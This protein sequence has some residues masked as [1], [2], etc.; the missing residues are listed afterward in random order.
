MLRIQ[1]VFIIE[2]FLAHENQITTHI[3]KVT[4]K[5]TN[6]IQILFYKY[7]NPVSVIL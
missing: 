5:S 4:Y 3:A 6:K 7:Q 1:N 2:C